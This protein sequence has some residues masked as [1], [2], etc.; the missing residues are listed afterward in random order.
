GE[1][2]DGKMR[3]AIDLVEKWDNTVSADSRG[4]VLFKTWWD[5][6]VHLAADGK[7]VESTPE[8]AGY[9]APAE[10]LFVHPWSPQA[11]T[12]TPSGLAGK[13]LAVDAFTWAIQE[14]E[15][16]YGGWDLSWGEVHRAVIGE[17]DY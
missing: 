7:R 13:N 12:T 11:P 3:Q 1:K 14:C 8:S 5:R 2:P 16:R 4:S 6:Y 17:Q 9:S 15:K 10:A